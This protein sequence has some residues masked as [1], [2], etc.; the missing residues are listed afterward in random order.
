MATDGQDLG[1][2]LRE[3]DLTAGPPALNLIEDRSPRG[4]EQTAALLEEVAPARIGG[5]ARAHLVG[6]TGPPGAGKS[7]LLSALIAHW[8]GQGRSVAVL[9]VDPS[10]KR[11]GGSLLG[12]RARIEHDPRDPEVL[13]RSTAAGGRLGGLAVPTREAATALAPAFDVVVVETVGVG[14]SETDVEEVC[15]TVAVVVQPGSGDTLQFIKAGIMEVPDVLVVTKSDLGD[16][17]DRARRDLAMALSSLGARKV[18]VV[19]TSSVAPP[20]DIDKLAGAIDAHREGLDLPARRARAR[21]LSA[22]AELVAEHGESALRALGG[23]RGA[24][25]LLRR[26]GPG[27]VDARAGQPAARRRRGLK[28]ASSR[29]ARRTPSGVSMLMASRSGT[30]TTAGESRRTVPVSGAS[31]PAPRSTSRQSGEYQ[32]SSGCRCPPARPTQAGA[33]PRP[34]STARSV[35]G[36]TNGMSAAHTSTGPPARSSACTIPVSGWRGSGGSSQRSTPSG[37]SGSGVSALQITARRSQTAPRASS[38]HSTMARPCTT[39]PGLEG[40]PMRRARP[41][42]STIPAGRV[43]ALSTSCHDNEQMEGSAPDSVGTRSSWLRCYRCWSQNLEV[44]LHYEGILKIDAETAEAV[45]PIDEVQEA[46][47]QC[48]DCMH[49]QP[50]LSLTFYEEDGRRVSRIEAVEDRWERMVTGTPWVASCTVTVDESEVETLLGARGGRRAGLRRVRRPRHARVL[51]PRAL[52]QARRLGPDRHPHA[53]RALRALLRR[54]QRGADLRRPRH[55]GA[56][57]PGRRVTP[58]R[59]RRPRRQPLT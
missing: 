23:R 17:A 16:V 4:R 9:A 5:E 35:S 34:A 50:H 25:K 18:P 10:S 48:M 8:R 26:H 33:S 31:S 51:H 54:G 11:S 47:V 49:D 1:R 14:Q 22:L 41:P 53:H 12:D 45:E 40:P 39:T 58:T 46:V 52:P 13:I 42:A 6:I 3:R 43:G 37:S 15:D 21:R 57:L 59:R 29:S 38:G 55:P 30:S 7:S 44:Q 2:R 20:K 24:E 19:A 36:V 27:R 56:D 32:A 28:P